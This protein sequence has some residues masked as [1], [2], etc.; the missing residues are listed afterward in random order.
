MGFGGGKAQRER[1]GPAKGLLISRRLHGD[2]RL[3]GAVASVV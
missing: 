3:G 1:E 2:E